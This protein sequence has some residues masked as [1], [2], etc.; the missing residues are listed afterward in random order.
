MRRGT[1]VILTDGLVNPNGIREATPVERIGYHR[2]VG[3]YVDGSVFQEETKNTAYS[4]VSCSCL[5]LPLVQRTLKN[6]AWNRVASTSSSQIHYRITLPSIQPDDPG[7]FTIILGQRSVL[8]FDRVKEECA[9]WVVGAI[10]GDV[11]SETAR[12]LEVNSGKRVF[13]FV[14]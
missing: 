8:L 7:V 9:V 12:Y 2:E 1:F 14:V 5:A 3:C 11:S 6:L 13:H 10:N 4:R